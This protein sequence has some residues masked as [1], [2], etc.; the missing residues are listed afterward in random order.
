MGRRQGVRHQGQVDLAPS[1]DDGDE[2]V[3][4]AAEVV[5]DLQAGLGF[6]APRSHSCIAIAQHDLLGRRRGAFAAFRGWP[7]WGAFRAS[8]PARWRPN[9]E[10]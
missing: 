1:T 7:P 8:R 9:E 3:I 5:V 6:Q 2:E 4:D 10:P